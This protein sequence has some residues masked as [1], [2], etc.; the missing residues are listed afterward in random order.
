M[1]NTPGLDGRD[2]EGDEPTGAPR[3]RECGEPDVR[4]SVFRPTHPA[5]DGPGV[6]LGLLLLMGAAVMMLICVFFGVAL[7]A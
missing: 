7:L 2:M 1:S 6:S 5:D 3:C 4:V